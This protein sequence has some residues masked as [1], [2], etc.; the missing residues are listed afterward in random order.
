MSGIVSVN[1]TGNSGEDR[2]ITNDLSVFSGLVLTS[3][4]FSLGAGIDHLAIDNLGTEAL[5]TVPEPDSL[6]LTA[7]PLG[8]WFLRRRVD[9]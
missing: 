4:E 3:V 9:R 2:D 1:P 5:T 7:L 6:L 8:A